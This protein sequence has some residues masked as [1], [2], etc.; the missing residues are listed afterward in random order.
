M[1]YYY[2][3]CKLLSIAV[4]RDL[5]LSGRRTRLR[6]PVIKCSQV[7][8]ASPAVITSPTRERRS[9]LAS[10][11]R[12]T[13]ADGTLP[14]RRATSFSTAL[15]SRRRLFFHSV[16]SR[17]PFSTACSSLLLPQPPSL[18]FD[19]SFVPF[20]GEA[21]FGLFLSVSLGASFNEKLISQVSRLSTRG[22]GSSFSS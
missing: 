1:L 22:A 6:W 7:T 4:T 11:W 21:V 10:P 16:S 15:F 19:S 2:S 13:S 9:S 3:P 20:R 8:V 18:R 17:R 5:E 14:W 12:G